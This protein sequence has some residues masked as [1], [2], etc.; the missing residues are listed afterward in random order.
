MEIRQY[1]ISAGTDLNSDTKENIHEELAS[2]LDAT[3]NWLKSASDAG[4]I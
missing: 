4:K 1:L 3:D 2:L